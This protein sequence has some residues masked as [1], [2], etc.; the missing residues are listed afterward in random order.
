LV[1]LTINVKRYEFSHVAPQRIRALTPIYGRARGALNCCQ[2]EAVRLRRLPGPPAPGRGT[3]ARHT[4]TRFAQAAGAQGLALLQNRM[5]RGA[6]LRRLARL[7]PA[8]SSSPAPQDIAR[9]SR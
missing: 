6:G 5:P 4:P 1:G 3:P 2:S 9:S 7:R 8:A